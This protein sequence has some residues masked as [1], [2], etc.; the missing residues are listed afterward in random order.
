MAWW[1]PW[2]RPKDGSGS[3][4]A[5]RPINGAGDGSSSSLPSASASPTSQQQ[6]QPQPPTSLHP[7]QQ[8]SIS[9]PAEQPSKAVSAM[10]SSSSDDLQASYHPELFRHAVNPNFRWLGSSFW[11]APDVLYALS[12]VIPLT[13]FGIGFVSGM[14]NGGSK[15]SLVFLAE[16]AHRRPDTVQG[17]YFYNKTK[18]Y[19]VLLSSLRGGG[20][21]G[22][23]LALLASLFVYSETNSWALRKEYLSGPE[24]RVSGPQKIGHVFD[25]MIAG[26]VVAAFASITYKAPPARLFA[27]STAAGAMMGGLQDLRDYLRGRCYE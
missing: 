22:G 6:L 21:T 23:R 1:N 16:N 20:A 12:P 11:L 5:A 25:G 10:S 18:N 19:K 8:R 26:Q 13:S 9:P 15:A 17:W 27:V 14:V 3:D 4:P 24:A 2:S 7:T